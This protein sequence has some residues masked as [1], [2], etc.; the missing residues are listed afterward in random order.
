L[1]APREERIEA[2]LRL[3]T[4]REIVTWQACSDVSGKYEQKN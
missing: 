1:I 2:K 4:S 3:R